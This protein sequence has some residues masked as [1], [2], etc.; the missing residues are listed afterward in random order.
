MARRRKQRNPSTGIKLAV[1]AAVGL[2]VFLFA[3]K[4]FG[5]QTLISNDYPE[6]GTYQPN[7]PEQIKLF[8]EAAA[9]AGLPTEWA[10]HTGLHHILASESGGKVGIPNYLWKAWTAKQGLPWDRS[11]WPEIWNVIRAGDAVPS[12]TGIKSH[13]AGLGQLQPS[14]MKK[15]QP[16]GL[17]GIGNPF[18]E[19]VGM[20]RY[21]KDRYGTIDKAWSFW[22]S[23]NWY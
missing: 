1:A 19:A 23:H 3:R 9:Y 7:S 17:K 21:I 2:G 16:S 11:S 8:E 12:K 10:S 4:A 15:Y 14:A 20:L 13:A 6:G 22:Q 5:S 18:E